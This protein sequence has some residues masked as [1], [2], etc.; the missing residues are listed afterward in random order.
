[1]KN[2]YLIGDCHL[3][4][5]SEHFNK[6]KSEMNM[7][8]WGKA[9]KSIYN[10][11][12]KKMYEEGEMSSGKEEQKFPNDGVISFS[13]IK[14]DGILFSWLGYVDVRTFL[15]KYNNADLVAKKYIDDL[16]E[17]FPN[18]KIIIIEPLPQFTEMLLKYDGISPSYTY[19]DRLKQNKLFLESMHKYAGIAGIKNFI[20]QKEIY[21]AIDAKEL[22]PEMTHNKAPHPVD[23]LNDEYNKKIFELFYKKAKE[24]LNE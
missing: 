15:T 6:E 5:V 4:R 23:G 2:V 22:T 19:E 16:V 10:I 13:E 9:A 12:F 11:D 21:D 3:A 17:N 7:V 20:T 24:F 14:D 18:S 1:M 8:F